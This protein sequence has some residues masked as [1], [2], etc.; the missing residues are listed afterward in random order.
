M[1]CQVLNCGCKLVAVESKSLGKKCL[2][3]APSELEYLH[4]VV[5]AVPRTGCMEIETNQGHVSMI[6]KEL[7]IDA[8]VKGKDLP[9]VKMT[10]VELGQVAA[11]AA[12]TGEKVW[13]YQSLLMRIA[14]L[15][16]DRADLLESV[17]NTLS[18]M[19]EDSQ[20]Q[21]CCKGF[22]GKFGEEALGVSRFRVQQYVVYEA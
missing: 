14:C 19:Q 2:H 6:L 5:R 20:Q 11:T 10:A 7:G 12:L 9:S 13:Q 3:S 1:Y 15:S 4:R 16:L 22:C 8:G 17:R 18:Q 21:F